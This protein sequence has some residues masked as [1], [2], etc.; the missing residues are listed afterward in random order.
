MNFGACAVE[1]KFGGA[2]EGGRWDGM[3]GWWAVP[4]SA[5]K[6][7]ASAGVIGSCWT[8]SGAAYLA[9]Q[10]RKRET[11]RVRNEEKQTYVGRRAEFGDSAYM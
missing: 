3:V 10:E 8:L 11:W 1:G 2:K 7:Q 9:G 5:D 6:M 4:L